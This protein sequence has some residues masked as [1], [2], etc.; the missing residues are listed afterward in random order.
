MSTG[1]QPV[2][3]EEEEEE[4]KTYSVSSG[5]GMAA[6]KIQEYLLLEMGMVAR[7]P[8]R[9]K[10]WGCQRFAP[11]APRDGVVTIIKDSWVHDRVRKTELFNN[12]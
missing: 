6:I 11:N 8:K 9:V 12:D 2:D 10:S 7:Y 1:H 4:E 5:A 3:E